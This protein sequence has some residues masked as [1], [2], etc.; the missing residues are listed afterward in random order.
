MVVARGM[1][2]YLAYDNVC[3]CVCVF[4]SYL[5][6]QS[7]IH[8]ISLSLHSWNL[9]LCSVTVVDHDFNLFN[10]SFSTRYF[11]TIISKFSKH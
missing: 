2:L 3:V 9:V 7:I 5:G 4:V 6:C 10:K 11:I 1:Y 8:C